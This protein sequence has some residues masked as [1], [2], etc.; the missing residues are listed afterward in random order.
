MKPPK[1]VIFDRS[2][3]LF[4]SIV[5][6][7]CGLS[8]I[9]TSESSFLGGVTWRGVEVPKPKTTGAFC[10]VSGA[11]A[12]VPNKEPGAGAAAAGAGVDGAPNL[13]T[14]ASEVGVAGAVVVPKV[15]GDLLGPGVETAAGCPN[16]KPVFP[17]K[18]GLG[19]SIFRVVGAGAVGV[20]GAAGA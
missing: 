16:G 12:G 7:R 1:P 9:M 20:D 4:V 8:S 15:N 18:S 14:P 6:E 19:V 2:G 10:G 5:I 3:L 17:P 11:A 13:K